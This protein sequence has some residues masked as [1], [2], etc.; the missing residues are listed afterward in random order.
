MILRDNTNQPELYLLV[1]LVISL[2]DCQSVHMPKNIFDYVLLERY[3]V[4]QTVDEFEVNSIVAFGLFVGNMKRAK[5]K[6][7]ILGIVKGF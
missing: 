7:D 6:Y 3:A 4:K 1:D 2:I 5:K